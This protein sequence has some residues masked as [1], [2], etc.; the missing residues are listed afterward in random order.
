VS[1][2][3]TPRRK[4]SP[5]GLKPRSFLVIYGT[6]EQAAENV[7]LKVKNHPSAAKAALISSHLTDGLK[8][9]PFKRRFKLSFS[10]SCEAVPFPRAW[11]FQQICAAPAETL[12]ISAGSGGRQP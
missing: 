3:F 5:Q 1:D 11:I 8:P 2:E 4:A 7:D 6:A 10:A 9:V 12:R